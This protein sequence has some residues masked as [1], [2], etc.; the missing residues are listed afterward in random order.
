MRGPDACHCVRA[1]CMGKEG[2]AATM[3]REQ[4]KDK[5]V[6]ISKG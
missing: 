1:D 5:D 2:G 4:V 6:G 3:H